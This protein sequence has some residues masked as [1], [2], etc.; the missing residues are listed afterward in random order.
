MIFPPKLKKGDPVGLISPCSHQRTDQQ[1]FVE[2]AIAVLE[3]WGLRVKLQPGQEQRHFYLAGTDEHRS[4]QFQNFYTNPDLKAL[5]ITRGG[6]GAARIFSYLNAAALARHQKIVVGLSDA[7]SLLLYLQKVCQMVVYHGPN[8]ATAQFLESPQKTFSHHSLH[9]ALFSQKPPTLP[10]QTLFHG[11]ATGRLVGGCLTLVVSSLGTT[12]EIETEDAILFLEDT[13]E[14]PYRVDRML[15]HLKNA[16]KLAA[17]RGLVFGE[18]VGCG[19]TDHCLYD[20]LKDYFQ[21]APFPVAYNLTS[22]HGTWCATL[23]LGAQATLDT[24]AETLCFLE[25]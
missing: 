10:V 15:T 18:M 13:H 5:F 4:T 16:G 11:T 22:G 6:Y 20:I 21:E 17:L 23:P 19:G 24:H 9:Q 14:A 2:E 7:T 8:V 1:H 12:H 25:S 3:S